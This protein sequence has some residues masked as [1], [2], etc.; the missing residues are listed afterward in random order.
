MDAPK[1]R[2]CKEKKQLEQGNHGDSDHNWLDWID[3]ANL[4]LLKVFCKLFPWEGNLDWRFLQKK[5][6]PCFLE[7]GSFPILRNRPMLG[8]VLKGT[9]ERR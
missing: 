7:T 6:T 4:D 3:P 9:Q 5:D 8:L 1:R 2:C